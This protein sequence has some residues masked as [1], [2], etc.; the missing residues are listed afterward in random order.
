MHTI[1]WI[2][3]FFSFHLVA[4]R[5]QAKTD[6]KNALAIYATFL[7]YLW[8]INTQPTFN[9]NEQKLCKQRKTDRV[10][11][12]RPNARRCTISNFVNVHTTTEQTLAKQTTL[13]IKLGVVVWQTATV[14]YIRLS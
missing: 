8:C 13:I 5:V 6:L 2:Y 1:Y 10:S 3:F 14:V 4:R 7:L 9:V 12:A 11:D